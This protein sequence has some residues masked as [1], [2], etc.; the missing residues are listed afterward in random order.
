MTGTE[1]LEGSME[2][3]AEAVGGRLKEAEAKK[4]FTAVALL[5]K[6]AIFWP[7]LEKGATAYTLQCQIW[8]Q[9]SLDTSLK[10]KNKPI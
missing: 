7:S 6:R 10:I 4:K 3:E 9:A 8:N 5:I 1:S 2:V